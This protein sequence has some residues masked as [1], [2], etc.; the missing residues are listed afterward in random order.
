MLNDNNEYSVFEADEY[1]NSTGSFDIEEEDDEEKKNPILSNILS[2]ILLFLMAA[3]MASIAAKQEESPVIELPKRFKVIDHEIVVDIPEWEQKR[4]G[5]TTVLSKDNEFE[6]A[7]TYDDELSKIPSSD[8]EARVIAQNRFSSDV[9]TKM[10]IAFEN[11]TSQLNV[12][13]GEVFHARKFFGEIQLVDGTTI[14][15]IGY[16]FTMDGTA[17]SIRG[18]VYDVESNE[19][20]QF[21]DDVIELIMKTLRREYDGVY[22]S[23]EKKSGT[24]ITEEVIIGDDIEDE[25]E[26]WVVE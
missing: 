2:V 23:N 25:N 6:I 11:L 8:T 15:E 17:C 20:I 14:A 10:D 4:Y 1:S 26:G 21:M 13:F 18:L 5:Y 12:E 24:P 16:A 9:I 7:I 22:V 3:A 19:K